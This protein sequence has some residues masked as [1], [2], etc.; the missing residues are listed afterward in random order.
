MK[1]TGGRA[2]APRVRERILERCLT[3]H[4]L[5]GSRLSAAPA[6]AGFW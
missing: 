1:T 2:D 5:T 6:R 3:G 4:R